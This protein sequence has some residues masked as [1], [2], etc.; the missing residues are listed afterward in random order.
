VGGIGDMIALG[1]SI[2]ENTR[3]TAFILRM[4]VTP[5]PGNSGPTSGTGSGSS[6]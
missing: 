3:R 1:V 6:G 5:Q 4:W 2:E